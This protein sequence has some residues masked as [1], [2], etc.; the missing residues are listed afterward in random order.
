MEDLRL[1]NTDIEF[2]CKSL[3]IDLVICALK[4]S[5]DG[6]VKKNGAYILN[7]DKVNGSGTHWVLLY[8]NGDEAIYFDSYGES[9]PQIVISFVKNIYY[10]ISNTDQIQDMDDN[11]SC[12]YYCIALA[13]FLNI[14]K[15]DRDTS[16]EDIMIKFNIV[17]DLNK[18]D[19]NKR[20]LQWMFKRMI[21][22][23]K[24]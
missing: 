16:L 6:T 8:V 17:F 3:K 5:L 22:N 11:I 18:T 1:S 21:S 4:D 7:L 12:G 14:M 2:I 15:N 13:Y 24:K 20:I 9:M 19:R 10:S 23:Y